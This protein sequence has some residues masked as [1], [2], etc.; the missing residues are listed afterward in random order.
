[1]ATNFLIAL[2]K[3]VKTEH[4]C[5]QLFFIEIGQ[6]RYTRIVVKY[7]GLFTKNAVLKFNEDRSHSV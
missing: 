6:V 3:P 1:M 4:L 5:S 2:V 7:N